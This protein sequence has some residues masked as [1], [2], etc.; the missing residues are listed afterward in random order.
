MG[1]SGTTKD[2]IR[3]VRDCPFDPNGGRDGAI[4]Y[5]VE[6]AVEKSASTTDETAST[7]PS[8]LDERAAE[9]LQL[10]NPLQPSTAIQLYILYTLQPS[11]TPLRKARE[12]GAKA[13]RRGVVRYAVR[14]PDGM[15]YA[16]AGGR[17]QVRTWSWGVGHVPPQR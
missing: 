6:K 3:V 14:N 7:S 2:P 16:V 5:A 10:Y 13:A 1:V 8:R 9:A 15:F 12:G 11:T 17:L 4:Q